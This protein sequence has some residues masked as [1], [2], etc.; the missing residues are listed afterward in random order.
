VVGARAAEAGQLDGAWRQRR[1]LVADGSSSEVLWL[2]G[3]YER[4]ARAKSGSETWVQSSPRREPVAALQREFD[5]GGGAL[6]L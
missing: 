1:R 3:V 2:E 5:E 4:L 6:V